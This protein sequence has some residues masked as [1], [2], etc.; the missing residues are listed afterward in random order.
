M[1]VGPKSVE[2]ERAFSVTKIRS[3]LCDRSVDD[4]CFLRAYFQ[5]D[6]TLKMN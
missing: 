3:Q 2:S 1:I 4:L 5:K 6:N